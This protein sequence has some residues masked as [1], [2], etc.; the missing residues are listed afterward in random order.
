MQTPDLRVRKISGR[1][2]ISEDGKHLID[3]VAFGRQFL[4][5][6]ARPP[7]RIS[8]RKRRRL[9]C[10][11][12]DEINSDAQAD[13]R[14]AIVRAG[15]E[16][17]DGRSLEEEGDD[18]ED[19]FAP[20]DEAGMEEELEGLEKD[21]NAGT[22]AQAPPEHLGRSRRKTRSQS[23]PE[24][25][26]LLKL[27]DEDGRPF[28]GIYSNPL[29][30]VYSQDEPSQRISALKVRKRGQMQSRQFLKSRIKGNAQDSSVTPE[31]P[32]RRDS[33]GSNKSVRFEDVEQATPVTIRES[34]DSDDEDD[35]DFEPDETDESDKENADPQANGKN[36]Q[37]DDVD[38]SDTTSSTFS[39]FDSSNSDDTSSSGSSS[40]STDSDSDSESDSEPEELS[41]SA[42]AH[43]DDVSGSFS[44]ES[45]SS[46]SS[47]SSSELNSQI[48]DSHKPSQISP[49]T[50]V[51]EIQSI[52]YKA[53]QPMK[54]PGTGKKGT[55]MRNQRRKETLALRKL[56]SNGI[57][58]DNS[59]KLD[60]R[61]FQGEKRA[62][63]VEGDSQRQE[64]RKDA[65]EAAFQPKRNAL[66]E[67][68]ASGEVSRDQESDQ[69]QTALNQQEDSSVTIGNNKATVSAV[70]QEVSVKS[71]AL[72]SEEQEQPSPNV[73]VQDS[74]QE[75]VLVESNASARDAESGKREQ[76]VDE[77]DQDTTAAKEVANDAGYTAS[78]N[79]NASAM[80]DSQPRRSKLDLAS[81]KRLLF[82]SLGLKAP[83]T[84]EEAS[85]LQA[86]LNKKIKPVTKLRVDPEAEKMTV[87]IEDE[88]WKD[89]IELS[90]VECCYDGVEYSAPPF[91]FVQRWDPQQQRGYRNTNSWK[92]T[93]EKKR[94][95]NDKN[96][97]ED[98]YDDSFNDDTQ[99][100]SARRQD[101]EPPVGMSEYE[102][103]APAQGLDSGGDVNVR[104]HSSQDPQAAINQL[105]R[106]T[107]DSAD[108]ARAAVEADDVSAL[109]TDLSSC[110]PLTKDD[111]KQGAVIAFKKIE[112]SLAN[113]WQ[114]YI[115]EHRTAIIDCMLEDG[116]L[117]MT[118]SKRDQP[119]GDKQYDN[120][121]GERIYGKFEMPGYDDEDCDPSKV[122]IVFTELIEPK[123]VRS[124]EDLPIAHDHNE[125]E[126]HDAPGKINEETSNGSEDQ[127]KGLD[128][129]EGAHLF[130]DEPRGDP[131]RCRRDSNGKLA[132]AD[133][134]FERHSQ[135]QQG[136][137]GAADE[138][139]RPSMKRPS[140]QARQEISEIFRDAGWRSSPGSDVNQQLD[141]PEEQASEQKDFD[142]DAPLPF[143]AASPKFI[144]LS[145]PV[146]LGYSGMSSP[147]QEPS[148]KRQAHSNEIAESVPSRGS[149]EPNVPVSEV[150]SSLTVEYP[151]LHHFEE[152]SEVLHSQR[153]H[154]S[155]SIEIDHSQASPELISP[156]SLRRRGP[157]RSPTTSSNS[158]V[159]EEI[160]A[161]RKLDGPGSDSDEFPT[162]FS[163][164]FESRLSQEIEIKLESSQGSTFSPQSKRK[165]KLKTTLKD[166]GKVTSSQP[167]QRSS[168]QERT[169][170]WASNDEESLNTL[171]PSQLSQIEQSSQI[172]D[173]T[174]S[175]DPIVPDDTVDDGDDSYR[176]NSSMPAGSGWVTKTK[177]KETGSAA[178]AAGRRKTT[179]R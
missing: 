23:T 84:K 102:A 158:Q 152:D 177:N 117:Q 125:I 34:E 46:D 27:V 93:K 115:S 89:K 41:S 127:I 172:V 65:D 90:A 62:P 137:D 22:G 69:A 179:S 154:R 96:Y 167:S 8:P 113:G 161:I 10:D 59:T 67:S 109:P 12:D 132:T 114:P 33:S 120:E 21:L 138:P 101:Y 103:E 106:E 155:V 7:I 77:T 95:R 148:S 37:K 91:P 38:S 159:K 170:R 86:E 47:S 51:D 98:Q 24:G 79:Q 15:F 1:H 56:I 20:G 131:A 66:L 75:G 168:T 74:N 123:L 173:L 100:K 136:F 119:D 104:A 70:N 72:N 156:P 99:R 42:P 55:R 166:T 163:Q 143:D 145:S 164:A 13:N 135:S 169:P 43:N 139:P 80:S 108:D 162:L 134:G 32:G 176:P 31:S 149:E 153:Q 50:S 116:T 133:G 57:L 29:L 83:K 160:K 60:M 94:K 87:D 110:A 68:I 118:W 88:S 171:R 36:P 45:T 81:S 130:H 82:G 157:Q 151:P 53:P 30:D 44:S 142:H 111:C 19:D 6:A 112:M 49:N 150:K 140:T 76:Q 18:D 61:R 11:E 122:D 85:S 4:R 5:K 28:P 14:Q 165:T 144:G 63:T 107:I 39:E 35:G 78:V 48:E 3:G 71:V 126:K 16:N 25:L 92:R 17:T 40:S 97:Y 58:P 175:S 105:V 129:K 64:A 52:P 146:G 178:Q 2:Q 73:Q 124:A 128:D 174:T 54:P 141:M 147:L 9:T 26:G 121:T